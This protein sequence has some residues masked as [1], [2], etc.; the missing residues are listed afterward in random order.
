MKHRLHV[1]KLGLSELALGR[2][3]GL[4]RLKHGEQRCCPWR[5]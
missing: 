4:P 3:Q 1:G 2:E 5:Y